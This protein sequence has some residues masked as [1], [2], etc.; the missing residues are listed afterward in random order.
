MLLE[1]KHARDLDNIAHLS[2]DP[3]SGLGDPEVMLNELSVVGL[4][5]VD[6]ELEAAAADLAPV[7]EVVA[8]VE[9]RF[10]ICAVTISGGYGL[11]VSQATGVV[12]VK[13]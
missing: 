1:V 8:L 7:E 13:R 3:F 5:N 12:G 11:E 9:P 2:V 6:V 4:H 10:P